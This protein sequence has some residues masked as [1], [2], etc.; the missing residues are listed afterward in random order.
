MFASGSEGC[1]SGMIREFE[2]HWPSIRIP[3]STMSLDMMFRWWQEKFIKNFDIDIGKS[4]LMVSYEKYFDLI[5]VAVRIPL[6]LIMVE[7]KQG[8]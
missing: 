2:Y 3:C 4:F 6:S 8:E 1:I 5:L 7:V